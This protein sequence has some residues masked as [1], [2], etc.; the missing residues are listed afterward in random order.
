[1]S[2]HTIMIAVS[3]SVI[4]MQQPRHYSYYRLTGPN[5]ATIWEEVLKLHS[6]RAKVCQL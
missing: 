2:K 1:M 4:S 6:F 5:A 3:I